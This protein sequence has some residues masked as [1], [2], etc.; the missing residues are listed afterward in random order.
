M[1]ATV[2]QYYES[3]STVSAAVQWK[4]QYGERGS[5]MEATVKLE[6]Q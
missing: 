6:Q 1:K 2:Q 4:Q 3:N 5:T